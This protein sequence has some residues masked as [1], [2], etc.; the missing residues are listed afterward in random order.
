MSVGLYLLVTSYLRPGFWLKVNLNQPTLW[1]RDP[2]AILK[3]VPGHLR[4]FRSC[5]NMQNVRCS[6]R[7]RC[8]EYGTLIEILSVNT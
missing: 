1:S 6:D 8:L 3:I 7:M 4:Y 2:L 5:K